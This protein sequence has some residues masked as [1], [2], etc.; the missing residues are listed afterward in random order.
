MILYVKLLIILLILKEKLMLLNTKIPFRFILNKI[1]IELIYVFLIALTVKSFAIAFIDYIPKMSLSI[2]AFIGTAISVLISFKMSQ[3]YERWWEARKIWGAIVND[4]RTLVLFLQSFAPNHT[5]DIQQITYRQIAW[6]YTLGQSLRD[7]NPYK[8]AE[9]F[10]SKDDYSFL[11][12]HSNKA[13]GI[14]QLNTIHIQ[15]MKD[16]GIF[17][18]YNHVQMTQL[19]SRFSDSMGMAERI[20]K[21]IFPAT[22]VKLLHFMIYIFV[23]TLS[24][25]LGDIDWFFELPLLLVISSCFFLLEKTA[26]HMQDPFS[27]K[28]SDTPVTTI[29]RSIEINLR[30]MISDEKIPEPYPSDKFY[31]L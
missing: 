30:Q 1:K 3:S 26:T 6:C 21:T 19:L 18:E 23:I 16:K 15:R 22:Y 5:R 7:L 28:P 27:N 24:I 29:S 31:Q 4:S 8:N 2:P 14:L 17:N 9:N 11:E 20:K 12:N 13:L 10:L 25:S